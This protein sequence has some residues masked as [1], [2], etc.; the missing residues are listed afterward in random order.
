VPF[1]LVAFSAA[2]CY[3]AAMN[4]STIVSSMV[5][6]ALLAACSHDEPSC[7]E[8][9]ASLDKN[10]TGTGVPN[11]FT[12]H[13]CKADHYSA[14]LRTCLAAARSV[15]GMSKCVSAIHQGC[16]K[17]AKGQDGLNLCADA[18]DR[19]MSLVDEAS[20]SL[21]LDRDK[22]LHAIENYDMAFDAW[23]TKNPGKHCPA[24]LDELESMRFDQANEGLE[25]VRND[26]WGTPLTMKC[27]ADDMWVISN[28]P[29]K[30]AGTAD[31]L[32]SSQV[33]QTTHRPRKKLKR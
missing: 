27:D 21:R 4:A 16:L 11:Y 3:E 18:R 25:L 23:S 30:V 19:L 33:D 17:N 9:V 22:T 5:C 32:D 15:N 7:K 24:S 20:A 29:D 14:S 12:E 13:S 1:D 28:G 10:L 31:D 2:R 26:Q 6:S 8:M